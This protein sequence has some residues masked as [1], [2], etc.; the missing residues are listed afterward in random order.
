MSFGKP[1]AYQKKE[2]RDVTITEELYKLLISKPIQ[3]RI[4]VSKTTY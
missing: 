1:F 3:G 4:L 2:T